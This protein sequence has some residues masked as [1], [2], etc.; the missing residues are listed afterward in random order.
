MLPFLGL[1]GA[2]ELGMWWRRRQRRGTVYAQAQAR[3]AL[4]GRPL[5]VIGAPD[6]GVTSGYSCGDV[7]IDL[8]RSSC[9]NAI[10]ADITQGI[11]LPDS[12]CVV[13][14]SCVL[15]YVADA[16]AALA[17]IQRISGG[18]AFFCG[19]EPLTATAYLYRGAKRTLPARLR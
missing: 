12:S 9:P 6:G 17:E 18:Q 10:Q 1:L 13:Y 7:T 8:A 19:V 14:V 11:P 4:L 16:R 15:E 2:Y 3:A 5:V